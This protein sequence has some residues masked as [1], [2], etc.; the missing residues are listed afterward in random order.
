MVAWY[1]SFSFLRFSVASATDLSRALMASSSASIPSVSVAIMPLASSMSFARSEILWSRLLPLS[2]VLSSSASQYAFLASSSVCSL[3]RSATMSSI[4]LR[5]LSK[6]TFLPLSASAMRSSWWF[7]PP[8]A[9]L[10]ALM[11]FNACFF[12]S[13]EATL[14]W[15][16]DG[17]GSVFLNRSN[18]SSS[19]R[20]LTVSAMASS[21]SARVFLTK[22]YSSSL[23]LQLASRSAINF[24]SPRSVIWVSSRSSFSVTIST[25]VLPRRTVFSSMALELAPISLVFAAAM[26]SMSATLCFSASVAAASSVTLVNPTRSLTTSARFSAG[27]EL[28]SL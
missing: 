9:R 18:E 16:K 17:L 15:I 8:A 24:W 19:L 12:T 3:P 10:A 26:A 11:A 22:P 2:S 5:T 13:L 6:L 28:R 20:I 25:P 1:S 21:S 4:I 7:L 27:R 23:V 14:V